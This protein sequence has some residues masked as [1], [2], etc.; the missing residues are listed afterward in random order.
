MEV[1]VLSKLI[2]V[3]AQ[4]N[5]TEVKSHTIPHDPVVEPVILVLFS[6]SQTQDTELHK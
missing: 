1:L 4:H 6:E 5:I 3:E 2:K